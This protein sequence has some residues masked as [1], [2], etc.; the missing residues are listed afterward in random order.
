MQGTIAD[1]ILMRYGGCMRTRNLNHS[2]CRLQHYVVWA[3]HYRSQFL[4]PCVKQAL[5]SILYATAK[6]YLT[7]PIE[8][9]KTDGDHIYPHIEIA[10]SV[11][12]SDA[13]KTLKQ[14][15]IPMTQKETP[16]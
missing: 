12:L 9:V 8:S 5:L 11:C 15:R 16:D 1:R 10:P 6:K 3:A 2:T 7:L 14:E 4:R 13:V